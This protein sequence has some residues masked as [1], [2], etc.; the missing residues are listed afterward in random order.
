MQ[1]HR[2]GLWTL[3]ALI[4]LLCQGGRAASDVA[5]KVT[6][7][8]RGGVPGIDAEIM[9]FKPSP[10]SSHIALITYKENP[11]AKDDSGKVLQSAAVFDV[12]KRRIVAQ[13]PVQDHRYDPVWSP[14]SRWVAIIDGSGPVRLIG[15]D[16][17][18]RN[19]PTKERVFSVLWRED[20]HTLIY[21]TH[22]D[23]NSVYEFDTASEKVKKI[24]TNTYILDLF[25]VNGK[26]GFAYVSGKDWN[27]RTRHALFAE[28]L[29]SRT[30][31]CEIP[32]YEKRKSDHY[33]FGMSPD[34]KFFSFTAT[35]SASAC[36]IVAR[37]EDAATVLKE[38]H[39]AVLYQDT[40]EDPYTVLW[41][42]NWRSAKDQQDYTSFMAYVNAD[43][44][45]FWFDLRNGSRQYWGC[46]SPVRRVDL[47][48]PVVGRWK[49]EE[50]T[51]DYIVLTRRGLELCGAAWVELRPIQLLIKHKPQGDY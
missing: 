1:R 3:V 18:C 26:P 32:L 46:D 51:A 30:P 6:L 33:Y 15:I 49:D 29:D 13:T 5:S 38:E 17:S 31:I 39:K 22:D 14:D 28:W 34:G 16:G 9:N 41:P 42:R 37:V 7:T 48:K 36:N 12:E 27:Y 11:K 8:V 40:I 25:M 43:F 2:F 21:L 50:I 24:A 47:W 35:A 23:A 19:L 4:A 45:C 20:A 44:D 10:D